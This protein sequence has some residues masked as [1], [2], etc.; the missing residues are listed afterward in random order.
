MSI[1]SNTINLNFGA[2]GDFV[3][4]AFRIGDDV[5][6]S[7]GHNFYKIPVSRY[8]IDPA[9]RN[10]NDIQISNGPTVIQDAG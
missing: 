5:W 9:D 7:V 10:A 4:S 6:L 3:G 1:K 8:E 2:T